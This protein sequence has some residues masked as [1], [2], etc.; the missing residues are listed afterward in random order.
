MFVQDAKQS[1]QII[2]SLKEEYETIEKELENINNQIDEIPNPDS[3][4]KLYND[5]EKK[6][7]QLQRL[8]YGIEKKITENKANCVELQNKTIRVEELIQKFIQN[9]DVIKEN[10]KIQLKI[11]ESESERDS[12]ISVVKKI[13]TDIISV[14]GQI[15]VC[16]KTISDCAD[17]IKKL[18]E[19][20]TQFKA[21]DFY[22]NCKS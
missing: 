15:K 19:L 10:Q 1:E 6:I 4:I 3:E 16:E 11:I 17:S 5:L 12:F 21:Y 8:V 9:E 7:L 13:D 18:Q 22:L 2:V 20:E 14:S